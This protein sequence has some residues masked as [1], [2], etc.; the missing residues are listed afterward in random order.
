MLAPPRG[1]DTGADPNAYKIQYLCHE[2]G[3][4][5][6]T[7]SPTVSAESAGGESPSNVTPQVDVGYDT[8]GGATHI[9]DERG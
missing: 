7:I 8:F 5:C 9:K 2:L 6:R 4:S 3:R 1:N